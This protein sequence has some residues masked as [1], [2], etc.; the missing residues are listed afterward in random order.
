ML[1]KTFPAILLFHNLATNKV[2]S[3][4]INHLIMCHPYV[5]SSPLQYLIGSATL[6]LMIYNAAPKKLLC[7]IAAKPFLEALDTPSPGK[8]IL[9]RNSWYSRPIE[10]KWLNLNSNEISTSSCHIRLAIRLPERKMILL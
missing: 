8:G 2:E 4:L 10:Q 3:I 7:L 1:F 6:L 5:H 9:L